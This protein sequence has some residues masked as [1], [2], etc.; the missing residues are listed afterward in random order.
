MALWPP[1]Q[2]GIKAFLRW[3]V[4]YSAALLLPWLAAGATIRL[5]L[6]SELPGA[7]LLLSVGLVASLWGF[8]PAAVTLLEG[9]LLFN[10]LL[11][12][13]YGAWSLSLPNLVHSAAF[14]AIGSLVAFFSKQRKSTEA[15][16]R[17]ALA[18]LQE[19]RDALVQAQIG[20]K[21]AAW[22]F[23]T[24]DRR[25][26]WFPGGPGIFGRSYEE[27]TE[28]GSPVELIE[29]EDQPK[30][31]EAAAR[32][33]QSG[34]AFHVQ[35]RVRWPNGEIHWL[36]ANGTPLIDNPSIWRGVTIDIT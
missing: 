5:G 13:P 8:G 28:M 11:T 2:T 31:A 12:P 4:A 1:T 10:N 36:E 9:T 20:A 6:R 30:V 27:I 21:A 34:V 29:A 35:F 23:T 33:I 3:A 7:F 32:T 25:T 18:T 19:Q 26:R 17:V 14:L 15:K 16:L 22:I 24:A